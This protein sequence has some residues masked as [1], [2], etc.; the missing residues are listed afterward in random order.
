MAAT[1]TPQLDSFIKPEIPQL[2]KTS[3]KEWARLQTFVLDALAPLTS[4]LEADAKGETISHDQALEAAKAATQLIGNASAQISHARK[5]KVLTHLN[6]S[7]LPLLEEDTNFENVAPSLFDP[8]FAR[9]SKDLVD[10]VR[11]ITCRSTTQKD[12]RQFFRQ[13]PP[14]G[15]LQSMPRERRR[16]KLR[17]GELAVPTEPEGSMDQTA[18]NCCHMY[19]NHLTINYK[20]TLAHQISCM[21]VN[22]L[23]LTDLPQAGRLCHHLSNWSLITQDRWVLNTVQGYQIDF[24]SEPHQQSPPNP[25]HYFSEQTSLIHEELAKLLKK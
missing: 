21:G 10:Q 20:S 12:L 2:V 6:K 8:E 7:L 18:M 14:R 3:D 22:N 4:L 15:G 9:K 23:Y 24:V 17:E 25:P 5:S 19:V 1:R 16:P 11:A 13:V